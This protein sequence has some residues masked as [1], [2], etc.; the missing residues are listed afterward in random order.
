M[1]FKHALV[2]REHISSFNSYCNEFNSML[3]EWLLLLRV[4]G[5]N[6]C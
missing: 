3:A 6:L 5:L 2:I 4:R 1:V